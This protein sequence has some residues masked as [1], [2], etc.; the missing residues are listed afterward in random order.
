MSAAIALDGPIS[1]LVT[2]GLTLPSITDQQ[3]ASIIDAAPPGST[4]HVAAQMRDAYAY[5]E[6]HDVDVILG[7]LPEK[8]FSLATK[9][10]WIHCIAAGVDAFLYPAMVDS[11]V[12]M[13][14]EKGLVGGH[15]ADTGFGLL[16]ALTRE[17][18]T[19]IR[20]GADG[21]NHREAMR[22][23]EVELEGATMGIVGLGGT[24]RAMARRAVAFG[25]DIIAVDAMP[26]VPSDGIKEVWGL[27]RLDDLL[28][29]SDVV[30][31]CCPLTAETA[32]LLDD[33]RLARVKRGAIVVNVTRG[34]V[35]DGD[36]LVRAL[37]SGH[38]GGAA[39]DVAPV[40]PL[41]ASHPLWTFDNVVMTP[42]TAGASQ[43][44]A[45]RNIDRFCENLRHARAGEPL[46]GLVDKHLGY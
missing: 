42:H 19:A 21:W 10:R 35:I 11:A 14:G 5:A 29:A 46:V 33:A 39:L 18:A 16:L 34:E 4:V 38:L 24:G 8:L 37:Q 12:V 27:E 3:V 13:T 41:P 6:Q 23:R 28:A 20:M 15:L 44:R 7:V 9:L 1:I 30:A 31:M 17:I 40:E 32:N 22:A 36:A 45:I 25:M 2:L 26:V 43:L